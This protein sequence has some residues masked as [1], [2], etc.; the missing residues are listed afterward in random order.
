MRRRR[1]LAVLIFLAGLAWG[2]CAHAADGQTAS[3]PVVSIATFD[4]NQAQI[5]RWSPAIGQAISGMLAESLDNAGGRFQV[6]ASPE[7]NGQPDESPAA[8]S[9]TA[10]DQGKSTRKSADGS[11]EPV[12]GPREDSPKPDA[13]VPVDSDFVLSGEVAE[14][15]TQTNSGR[16]G[17]F[18]S[19]NPFANLG[20]KVVTAHV[21]IDWRLVD[22]QTKRVIKRGTAIGSGHG[23]EFVMASSPEADATPAPVESASAGVKTAKSTTAAPGGKP[24]TGGNSG[25]GNLASVN[26]IFNGF[27][28]VLGNPPSGEAGS[29]GSAAVGAKGNNSGL[30]SKPPKAPPK[31]DG[32]VAAGERETIGYNNSLFMS[33]AL[34]IATAEAVT[35]IMAQLAATS[36]PESARIDKSRSASDTLKHT[37]GK[38]LAVAGKDAIIV[39]LGSKQGFKAG[40]QLE[41]CQ[42]S[43]VKDD[44]GNV[45][46]T[47]EKVVGEI[48]LSEVQV[49]R[50]RASYSGDLTIQ[51]GWTVKAK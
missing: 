33:S 26:N 16:I 20:A 32:E 14:F 25:T 17:D 6:L 48:T 42:T 15:G 44:K 4:G 37:P 50:S 27:N 34:G 9:G 28:K 18:I 2:Y 36:L 10:N 12:A 21:R 22:A 1:S 40:D 19:S 38:I 51:Q 30:T 13:S 24:A 8:K 45:V 41:L 43:D 46:F 5:P 3:P 23:S 29:G 31:A 35:N 11:K 7:A 39:S 49:D 47:D